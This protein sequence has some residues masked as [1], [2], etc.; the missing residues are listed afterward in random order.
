MTTTAFKATCQDIQGRAGCGGRALETGIRKTQDP[1]LRSLF[2]CFCSS[3]DSLTPLI[4]VQK[5]VQPFLRDS[6]F[7]D[8]DPKWRESS[9]DILT[10]QRGWPAPSSRPCSL[11]G[12]TV[13]CAG[14]KA[15]A[16]SSPHTTHCSPFLQPL[17]ARDREKM[18]SPCS[19]GTVEASLQKLRFYSC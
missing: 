15:C 10:D 14:R 12:R 18:A 2:F 17:E 7:Y 11:S 6:C 5:R 16:A 8:Y 19:V 4:R 1:L 3:S 9:S 13:G